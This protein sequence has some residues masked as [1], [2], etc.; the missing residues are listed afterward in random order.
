[1]LLFVIKFEVRMVEV[2][3]GFSRRPLDVRE[4]WCLW[5]EVCENWA[6]S[7]FMS[8]IPLIELLNMR[9]VLLGFFLKARKLSF[10]SLMFS[11]LV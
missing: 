9:W 2:L 10:L 11:F 8:L 5:C 6:V 7:F 4:F 3:L 1:M